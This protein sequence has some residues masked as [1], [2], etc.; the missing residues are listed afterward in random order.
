MLEA[1]ARS[2]GPRGVSATRP[3][4]RHNAQQ[5]APAAAD[6]AAL[7]Y[8]R[9]DQDRKQYE[10]TLRLFE[11]GSAVVAHRDIRTV[12][13]PVMRALGCHVDENVILS[14]RDGSEVVVLDPVKHL[15]T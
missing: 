14:V 7:G 6:I 5:R 4:T 2:D 10:P 9:Q 8:V 15:Y 11:L 13:Q 3:P 12:S 1:V